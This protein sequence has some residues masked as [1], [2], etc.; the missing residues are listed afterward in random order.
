MIVENLSILMTKIISRIGTVVCTFLATTTIS[1]T[2][3]AVTDR[4]GVIKYSQGRTFNTG[5]YQPALI[6]EF[7][8][9]KA[10]PFLVFSGL[11]CN[12]CDINRNIYIQSP[13]EGSIVNGETGRRYSYPGKYKDLESKALVETVR[14][15]V[16]RCTPSKNKGMVWFSNT[17]MENGTWQRSTYLAQVEGAKL[18][19]Y[20]QPS[21]KVSL[22]SAQRRVAQRICRELSGRSFTTEP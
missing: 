9:P 15:F 14:T 12:N 7:T 21:P 10:E 6:A 5:V 18:I 2:T 3:Q 20:K 4:S 11:G 8:V 19:E 22:V 17:K 1:T 16:G 13:A